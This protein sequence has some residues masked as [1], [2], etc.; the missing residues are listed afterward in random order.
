MSYSLSVCMWTTLGCLVISRATKRILR[1]EILQKRQCYLGQTRKVS[2]WLQR[3]YAELGEHPEKW[4][5][6][7]PISKYI[8]GNANEPLIHT[9]HSH[10]WVFN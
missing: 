1:C 10:C 3:D 9:L 7:F 5:A 8:L 4:L 6:K 2:E